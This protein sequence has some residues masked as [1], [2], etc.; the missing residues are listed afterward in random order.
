MKMIAA[1][2]KESACAGFSISLIGAFTLRI[3]H[4]INLQ[5]FIMKTGHQFIYYKII[6]VQYF[7]LTTVNKIA[8]WLINQ[9]TY[10][11]LRSFH[12]F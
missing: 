6:S 4:I 7:V 2:Q 3:H 10:Y 9:K 1:F 12:S 8:A 5:D 11:C